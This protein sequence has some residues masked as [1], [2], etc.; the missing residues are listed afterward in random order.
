MNVSFPQ[1]FTSD[2]LKNIGGISDQ[3]V[4]SRAQ[5]QDSSVRAD[6]VYPALA[7]SL[8]DLTSLNADLKSSLNQ[9]Q[10][11]QDA[12]PQGESPNPVQLEEMKDLQ[13]KIK[14][15]F[16][17]VI[18]NL[19]KAGVNTVNPSLLAQAK[20]S[21]SIE[22]KLTSLAK[23]NDQNPLFKLMTAYMKLPVQTLKALFDFVNFDLENQDAKGIMRFRRPGDERG[24][25]T[26]PVSKYRLSNIKSEGDM[27]GPDHKHRTEGQRK[28][29]H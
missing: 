28:K 1:G 24:L 7:A 18:D 21:L 6:D 9:L 23:R 22:D 27:L 14:A 26:L 17:Q 19:E 25:V 20:N 10:D 29:K 15:V 4:W 13:A 8:P 2:L 5:D 11:L 3:E 12:V 16:M